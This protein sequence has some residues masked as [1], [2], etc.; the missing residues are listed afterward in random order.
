MP[1]GECANR[2]MYNRDKHGDTCPICGLVSKK[3]KEDNK[4]PEEIAKMLELP[5]GEYVCAWL[6]CVAGINKGRSYP[7]HPEKTFIGSGDDM[8]IQIL[9][10]DKIDRYRHAIIVYDGKK[11]EFILL[12]GEASGLTYL[13]GSAVYLPKVLSSHARIELGDSK[14]TFIPF[15]GEL[16]DWNI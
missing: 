2:H 16:F 6:V 13:D 15:C 11:H 7:V 3:S 1:L 8:D 12:P 9:G 14:F 10:D 5:R 4:T